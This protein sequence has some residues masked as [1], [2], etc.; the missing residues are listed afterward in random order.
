MNTHVSHNGK[1]ILNKNYRFLHSY[2]VTYFYKSNPG[3]YITFCRHNSF[4]LLYLDNKFILCTQETEHNYWSYDWSASLTM[5]ANIAHWNTWYLTI[6]RGLLI[7]KYIKLMSL[8]F[9]PPTGLEVFY[10]VE[11]KLSNNPIFLFLV[12]Y[13]FGNSVYTHGPIQCC[14]EIYLGRLSR[15]RERY[16]CNS[17]PL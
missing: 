7:A 15:L 5:A 4:F 12:T 2:T 3:L 10:A 16:A 1:F 14:L 11:A 8:V 13:T 9:K 17:F 6:L